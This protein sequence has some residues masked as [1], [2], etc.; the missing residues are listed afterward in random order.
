MI[1]MKAKYALKALGRLASASPGERLHIAD[2]AERERIP[3]KF[4]E[5]ILRELTQHGLLR[6]R[7]G[8]GGGYHFARSPDQV[9]VASVLRIVDGPI[10]PVPCLSRTAYERCADCPDER[11]CG[12]RL[13]MREAYE[14]AVRALDKTTFGDMV[15]SMEK[16]ER[17]PPHVP[18]YSI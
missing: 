9:T 4:L 7:K 2:I 1:T 6:S 3:R 10:A 5:L 15:R 13:A 11:T 12:V 17:T 16:A 18:R 8:R 14:A